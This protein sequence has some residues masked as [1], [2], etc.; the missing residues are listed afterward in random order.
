MEEADTM[1]KNAHTVAAG[2]QMVTIAIIAMKT[3]KKV[4]K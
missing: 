1:M 2:I 3:F 4:V